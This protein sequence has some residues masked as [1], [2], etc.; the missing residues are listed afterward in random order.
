M[1]CIL[2]AFVATIVKQP[3]IIPI[4]LLFFAIVYALIMLQWGRVSILVFCLRE[5]D[6]LDKQTQADYYWVKRWLARLLRFVESQ[7]IIL[8]ASDVNIN[9][10]YASF[11]SLDEP[12]LCLELLL[13]SG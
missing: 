12:A 6:K 10:L 4:F 8:F 3:E 9:W 2:L 13:R 7:P 11:V 1:A 5:F